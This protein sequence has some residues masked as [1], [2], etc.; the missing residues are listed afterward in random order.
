MV[1]PQKGEKATGNKPKRTLSEEQLEKLKIAREK[2]LEVKRAMKEKSDDKKIKHYEE[3]IMKI[4][5]KKAEPKAVEEL[6]EVNESEEEEESPPEVI[7]QKK[8]PKPKKKP[9][10]IYE[11]SE[12][13]SDDDSNVIYIKRGNKSKKK[14]DNPLVEP[15]PQQ[16]IQQPPPVQRQVV[17]NPNPFYRYNLNQHYM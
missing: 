10:V 15:P 5:G 12:S 17:V 16:V 11:Q 3:K 7:V 6:E 9:V 8:K 2:A 4:K 1:E 14:Q 13:E